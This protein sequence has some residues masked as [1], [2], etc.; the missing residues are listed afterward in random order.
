M[1]VDVVC[2]PTDLLRDVP[3]WAPVIAMLPASD[4][5][6]EALRDHCAREAPKVLVV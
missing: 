4:A 5:H 1:F 6:V 3:M 2:D